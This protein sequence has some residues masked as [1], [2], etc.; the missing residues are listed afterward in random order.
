M[1]IASMVATLVSQDGRM[2]TIGLGCLL[3]GG[4]PGLWFGVRQAAARLAGRRALGRA[5]MTI[6]GCVVLASLGLLCFLGVW[7]A[8]LGAGGWVLLAAVLALPFGGLLYARDPAKVLTF[9]ANRLAGLVFFPSLLF[10]AFFLVFG[11]TE[12]LP[13]LLDWVVPS[14]LVL[15]VTIVYARSRGWVLWPKGSGGGGG[16]SYSGS[17]YSSGGSSY[18]GSSGGGSSYSGGGGSSGGG[19]AS[20]S[21]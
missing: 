9:T 21:W 11:T 10:T 5:V 3:W 14:G 17:G 4:V 16:G 7:G 12:M 18:S 6:A 20:G 2:I 8:R 13:A 1:L 15:L 19:G